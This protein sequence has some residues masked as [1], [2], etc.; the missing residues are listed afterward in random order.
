MA[1][2]SDLSEHISLY[3]ALVVCDTRRPFFP[4]LGILLLEQ[5]QPSID[6]SPR[7][8]EPRGELVRRVSSEA[9]FEQLG[10]GFRQSVKE[11]SRSDPGGRRPRPG[12][13]GRG[14]RVSVNR[15][16][17]AR[18]T[19]SARLTQMRANVRRIARPQAAFD[20]VEKSLAMSEASESR[21][22]PAAGLIDIERRGD[23]LVDPQGPGR[24]VI[25]PWR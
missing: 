20:V 9:L 3:A 12:P 21:D 5:L 24:P 13:R 16:R 10:V 22:F 25:G 4:N 8:A 1:F 2:V 15:Y 14:H 19:D 18:G 23:K 6:G 11:G 17:S 7:Q